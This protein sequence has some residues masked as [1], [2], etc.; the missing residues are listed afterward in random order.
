MKLV[1]VLLALAPL[2]L[3]RTSPTPRE[4]PEEARAAL[5]DFHAEWDAA[6]EAFDRAALER[7]LTEDFRVVLRQ[8]ELSR[9]EFL[10]LVSKPAPG[11]RLT[12]FASRVLTLRRDGEVWEAIVEEKLEAETRGAD[13]KPARACSLWITRDRFRPGEPWLCLSSEELGAEFWAP[14]VT[15]PI[16]GWATR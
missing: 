11:A 6:R 10:E 2:T 9:D 15:P 14:G 1:L 3:L 8:G 16:E 13:G 5:L 4:T 7:R 12:R